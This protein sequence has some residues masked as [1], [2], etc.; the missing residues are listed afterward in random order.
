MP[1]GSGEEAEAG[2]EGRGASQHG[3]ARRRLPG[4][5]EE[6]TGKNDEANAE[7]GTASEGLSGDVRERGTEQRRSGL[8]DEDRAPRERE[9]NEV[10]SITLNGEEKSVR[11]Q[12]RNKKREGK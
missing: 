4:E 8:E 11:E 7:C 1:T 6:I 10:W 3:K 9:A 12:T 2:A 5:R